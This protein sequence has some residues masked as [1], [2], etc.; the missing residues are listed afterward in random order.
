MNFKLDTLDDW[1]EFI[2]KQIP[3]YYFL[4]LLFLGESTKYNDFLQKSLLLSLE[5]EIEQNE[6]FCE[7]KST[8]SFVNSRKE[9]LNHIIPTI[10]NIICLTEFT[11]EQ[12]D[13]SI[14]ITRLVDITDILS[15]S[16]FKTWY[17]KYCQQVP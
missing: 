10:A 17:Y 11:L 15:S 13:C 12:D 4:P 2:N 5:E 6:K 7:K 8:T 1:I 16:T 3:V 14:V 9:Y